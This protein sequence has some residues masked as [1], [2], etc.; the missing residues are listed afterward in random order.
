MGE[1]WY[2]IPEV[3]GSSPGPLQIFSTICKTLIKF[4]HD[5]AGGPIKHAF[6]LDSKS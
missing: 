6:G 5:I 2:G 4:S 3:S 1:H